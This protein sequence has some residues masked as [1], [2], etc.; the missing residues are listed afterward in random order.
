MSFLKT[1]VKYSYGGARGAY[2][3][4][5]LLGPSDA[6]MRQQAMPLL[7]QI[8]ACRLIGAKPLSEPMLDFC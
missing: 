2:L 3:A 8:N 1:I 6:Y 4:H 5:G 7:A